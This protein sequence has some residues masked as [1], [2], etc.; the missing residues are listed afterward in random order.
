MQST[1]NAKQRGEKNNMPILLK[2]WKNVRKFAYSQENTEFAALQQPLAVNQNTPLTG[3]RVIYEREG[4]A[5]PSY[6]PHGKDREDPYSK[7]KK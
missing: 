7:Y 6:I 1:R 2:W 4:D 3:S 5:L